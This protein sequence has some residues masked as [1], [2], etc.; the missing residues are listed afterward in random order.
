MASRYDSVRVI[1]KVLCGLGFRAR[2]AKVKG[3]TVWA[4]FRTLGIY[5]SAGEREST[6]IIVRG[7]NSAEVRDRMWKLREDIERLTA[8]AGHDFYVRKVQ[9][10]NTV[11]IVITNRS[12]YATTP[13]VDLPF[14]KVVE[15]SSAIQQETVDV[16]ADA[17]V[18]LNSTA[19]HNTK[20][21]TVNTTYTAE[22]LTNMKTVELRKLARAEFGIKGMSS[23]RKEQLVPAILQ[24]QAMRLTETAQANDR[25]E[26]PE[27]TGPKIEKPVGQVGHAGAK[28]VRTEKG[29][30][31]NLCQICGEKKIDRKTQG[32]DSTMCTECFEY[33]GWENT[34][35]DES[36]EG[37]ENLALRE[38]CP[39]C[40]QM[41]LPTSKP[42][43]DGISPKAK[44]FEADALKAGWSAL[45]RVAAD[46]SGTS[47]V[48][49]TSQTGETIELHWNGRVYDYDASKFTANGHRAV[50]V[51]NAS[52]ARKILAGV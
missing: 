11:D 18:E 28:A 35:S 43:S 37:T 44:R 22:T 51:R 52:A 25:I 5:S 6:E 9:Y 36:H 4:D 2:N 23:A 7:Y 47:V 29:V 15:E 26:S 31:G 38:G 41:G 33:A 8:E 19:G 13:S 21:L 45:A 48:T 42:V 40:E 50:K 20:E 3:Y 24:E 17:G 49:A 10:G 32:R 16:S 12:Y 14:G 39:V 27:L 34:H 46:G 30:K 1:T